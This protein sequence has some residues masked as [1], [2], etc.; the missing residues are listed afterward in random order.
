MHLEVA[1]FLNSKLDQIRKR[2]PRFSVRAFSKRVNI[3]SG[4]ISELLNGQRALSRYYAERISAGLKFEEHETKELFSLVTTPGRKLFPERTLLEQELALLDSWEHYAVLNL[5]NLKD[6]ESDPNWMA[7]R[8]GITVQNV[9]RSLQV[10][11]SLQLISYKNGRY[12][13][14]QNALTTSCDIP[15]EALQNAHLH[16]LHKAQEMLRKTPVELRDYSSMAMA[17]N[18]KNIKKAKELIEHFQDRMARLLEDGE[19]TE[20]YGMNIQLYPMTQPVG[21]K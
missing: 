4:R 10:L 13:R 3:S 20:V 11:S 9:L 12:V 5:L 7:K 16:D 18:P 8:L 2:N 15:S 1:K 14:A 17:I 19:K 21:K 6:F